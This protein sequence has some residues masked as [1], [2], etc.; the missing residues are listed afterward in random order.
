MLNTLPIILIVSTVLGLLAGLGVGG[1]SLLIL[2]LT[3]ILD[4]E[5]N[6]ARAMNLMFFLPTAV[7]SSFFRRK[8]G[9]LQLRKVF[10][11]ILAGCITAAIF[12]LLSRQITVSA[13]QKLFGVLLLV[14]GIK[15]IMY[16]PKC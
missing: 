6:I 1:G 2:W 13:L 3:L 7:I 8:Q 12:S 11:G 9:T 15:E 14:T 16:K 4:T 5:A 10:P